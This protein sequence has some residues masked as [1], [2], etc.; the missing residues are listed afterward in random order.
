M[1]MI[2]EGPNISN[3]SSSTNQAITSVYVSLAQFNTNKRKRSATLYHHRDNETPLPVYLGLKIRGST[4]SKNLVDTL[5]GL[6]L[7]ISYQGILAV[8]TNAINSAT[9]CSKGNE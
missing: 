8:S 2:L 4:R 6:G 3:H 5:F 1:Q 7:S 9:P